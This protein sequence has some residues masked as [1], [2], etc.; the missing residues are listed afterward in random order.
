MNQQVEQMI[1]QALNDASVEVTSHGNHF[2]IT[3]TSAQFAGKS[4]L[5][6]QRMVYSAIDSLMKGPNPPIHAVDRLRTLLPS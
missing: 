5:E 1:Q 6:Q 3:V 4:R 2:E